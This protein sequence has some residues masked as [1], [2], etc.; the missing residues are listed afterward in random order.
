MRFETAPL[1]PYATRITI[2]LAWLGGLLTLPLLF[3]YLANLR[4]GGLLVPIALALPLALFLLLNYAAQASSYTIEPE[5]LVIRR[6][7]WRPL[8]VPLERISGVSSASPLSDV[9]KRGLRFA[10]NAGIFGYLGPFR[11]D[12][13]GQVFFLATN[14]T[15]LVAV[16]RDNKPPLILSPAK[17]RD[18]IQ[19]LNERRTQSAVEQLTVEA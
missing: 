11:L 13:Y 4:W 3:A 12:P 19:A 10:F 6:R 5:A 17:P 16:A 18:F 7:W 9:P 8:R 2:G 15:R 1:D 14:R